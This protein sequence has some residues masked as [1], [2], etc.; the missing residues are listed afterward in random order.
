VTCTDG[1]YVGAMDALLLLTGDHNR[2]RGLFKRFKE[3]H[4][5]KDQQRGQ[6]VA[7]KIIRE[8]TVHTEIEESVFY[9]AVKDAGDEKLTELVVEG[10][11]EHAVVK[12]LISEV[13][14][15]E[16]GDERWH[17]KMTVIIE[18]VEHHAEEE[19]KEMWTKVRSALDPATLETLAE[20]LETKK[21]ELGA[22]TT[23]DTIDL[24]KT[25]LAEMAKEQ[26]IPGRSK[27][28]QEELAATVSPG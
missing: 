19:E 28:T 14:S 10:Y 15:C 16:P 27:M 17:A 20:K 25:A 4:E 1:G 22:P 7:E 13:Q 26:E 23:A 8:L 5:K 3:A 12:E 21:R 11:E 24:T 18:N 2:V 6:Q 9:P